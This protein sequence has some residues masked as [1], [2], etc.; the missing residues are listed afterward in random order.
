MPFPDKEAAVELFY[1]FQGDLLIYNFNA[2]YFYFVQGW[3][4]ELKN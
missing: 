3:L 4:I 2:I 1:H